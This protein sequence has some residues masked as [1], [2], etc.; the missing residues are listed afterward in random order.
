MSKQS[1]LRKRKSRENETINQSEMRRA[2][3]RENKRL[4]RSTETTEQ[5]E[6]RLT[7][8]R[9]QKRNKRKRTRRV[10]G[11]IDERNNQQDE[12]QNQDVVNQ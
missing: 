11:D 10:L 6:A 1:T 3:D 8:E 12:I 5:R 2:K 9:E 7:R 4:K